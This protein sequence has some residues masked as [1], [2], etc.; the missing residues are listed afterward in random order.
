MNTRDLA[1]QLRLATIDA[2]TK[3]GQYQDTTDVVNTGDLPDDEEGDVNAYEFKVGMMCV[4]VSNQGVTVERVV[5][6]VTIRLMQ[7][8]PSTQPSDYAQIIAALATV[9]TGV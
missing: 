2:C 1:T 7:N 8:S 5:S 4:T 3:I 6:G 9:N